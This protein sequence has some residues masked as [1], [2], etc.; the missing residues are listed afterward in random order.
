LQINVQFSSATPLLEAFPHLA[1]LYVPLI[2]IDRHGEISQEYAQAFASSV[3][4]QLWLR[5]LLYT[6]GLALGAVCLTLAPV[7]GVIRYRIRQRR[8]AE[9]L[10][11]GMQ[12]M[13]LEQTA[14]DQARRALLTP[15]SS[16]SS[17]GLDDLSGGTTSGAEPA[18][19][20][21]SPVASTAEPL[22]D[23]A[24]PSNNPA[25]Q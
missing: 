16:S 9:Q 23:A 12:L 10:E 11:A 19:T 20:A 14:S 13:F 21:Q 22:D 7:L 15:E 25:I 8:K 18:T 24:P 17:L 2:W 5:D 6:G 1:A 4:Y 3:T